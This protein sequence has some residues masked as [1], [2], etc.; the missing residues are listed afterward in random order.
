M[1]AILVQVYL[2]QNDSIHWTLKDDTCT[3]K[4]AKLYAWVYI[5]MPII[6]KCILLTSICIRHKSFLWNT[7]G[8]PQRRDTNL[9]GNLIC[10]GDLWSAW[11]WPWYLIRKKS[12]KHKKTVELWFLN[13]AK[14]TGWRSSRQFGLCPVAKPL[15]QGSASGPDPQ[16]R[17]CIKA[18]Q[19]N[20]CLQSAG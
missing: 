12:T 20:I 2:S 14:E 19:T 15:K 6:N 4:P 8:A 5:Y 13:F 18:S 9:A 10:C 17:L 1:N 3:P 16:N 11:N 7:W